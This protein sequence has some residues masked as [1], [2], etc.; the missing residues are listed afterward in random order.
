MEASLANDA[1]ELES[2]LQGGKFRDASIVCRELIS[3]HPFNALYHTVLGDI[4]VAFRRPEL[5][6]ESY[7]SA[8]KINPAIAWLKVNEEDHLKERYLLIKPWGAGFW[9]DM[10]QV[11]GA[12]LAAELTNRTPVVA[13]GTGSLFTPQGTPNGWD[14]YFQPVSDHSIPALPEPTFFPL[15]W[16]RANVGLDDVNKWKGD[17][18]RVSVLYFF[19]RPEDVVIAD[20]FDNVTDLMPWIDKSSTYHGAKQIE[21]YRHLLGKFV[22]LQARLAAEIDR[23]WQGR[24]A[25]N[26]WV[27]VHMRGTDKRWE[28]P[29]LDAINDAYIPV[30]DGLLAQESYLKIFLLTDSQPM[31]ERMLERY[32]ER[33]IHTDSIRG[34]GAVGVH[35]SQCPKR[36]IADQAIIDTYLAGRCDYFLGNGASNLSKAVEFMK[37]WPPGTY[38]LLGPD[39]RAVR[40]RIVER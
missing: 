8:L 25:G 24:M 35:F 5:A 33:I 7:Q 30:L 16:S 4:A 3:R 13:W 28:V 36:D 29:Q 6:V 19:R 32:G 9:S 18:S 21:I 27:A 2:L 37:V 23:F 38:N 12:L 31:L 10:D 26:K 17:N 20:F 34:A 39:L 14:L 40:H 15:K 1:Q 22:R 11:F